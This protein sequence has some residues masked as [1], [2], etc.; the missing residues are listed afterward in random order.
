[1]ISKIKFVEVRLPSIY[2]VEMK[3]AQKVDCSHIVSRSYKP[4][5]G[6]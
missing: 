2:S 3:V 4:L 1:M 5:S 6:G